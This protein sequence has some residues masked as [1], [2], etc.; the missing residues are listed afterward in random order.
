MDVKENER[1]ERRNEPGN[2]VG[3]NTELSSTET[4]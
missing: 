1:E 2:A 3:G 4:G